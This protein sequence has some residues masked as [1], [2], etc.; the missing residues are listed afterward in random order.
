MTGLLLTG[1]VRLLCGAQA[2][3]RGVA[4][5]PRP[6]IYFANHTS[7]LDALVIW[8]ALPSALRALTRPVAAR[9]YWQGDAVRR[10]LATRVFNAVLIERK[11]VTAGDNPI[12]AMI[13]AMGER[14][15]LIIFPEGGR[16]P[17]PEP[18]PFKAGL[19]HLAKHR[20]DAELV[21]VYLENLN[22]VL[23]KGEVLP[24]PMLCS[25]TI[26]APIRLE[27]GEAKPDFLERARL[28]V[29]N[30]RHT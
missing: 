6:R 7:N 27:A 17:G 11:K 22:R 5:E 18:V 4:P 8:A 15:S 1:L 9:D 13:A 3:W 23:P 28:A 10:Y 12:A 29:W 14:H 25:L 24:V 20:P 26:G 30:L 16:H 21:P 19:F 2:H